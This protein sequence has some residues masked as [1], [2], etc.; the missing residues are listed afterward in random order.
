MAARKDTQR[1]EKQVGQNL[2]RHKGKIDRGKRELNNGHRSGLI[3]LTGL[4]GSG[5]STLAHELEQKLFER[6]V[7]AYVLDGDNIRKGLNRNLGFSSQDR[8]ENIRRIGEVSKLFVDAGMIVISAFISPYENDRAY[9]RDLI[10]DGDFM[11]VYCKSSLAKCEERDVK[12]LY[13]KARKGE[14][15][16]FTGISAPY[17]EPINPEIIVDTENL[18]L[19]ECVENVLKYLVVNGIVHNEIM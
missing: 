8:Q 5:K 3:W 15:E 14:I 6:G 4:S 1:K 12:G 10:S 17:E 11:E 13:K 18:S 16:N 7:Q 19:Q 2:F 9:A